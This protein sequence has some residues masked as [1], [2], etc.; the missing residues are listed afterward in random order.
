LVKGCINCGRDSIISNNKYTTNE[1]I[2]KSNE[3]HNNKYDY[4]KVNYINSKNKI[5]IICKEHGEFIQSPDHHLQGQGC[6]ICGEIRTQNFKY[7]NTNQFIEKSK[8]I[9]GNK[10]DYSKT[11]YINSHTNI[12]IICKEHG[13]FYI[14]PN[15]HINSNQGCPKCQKIKQYSKLSIIWLNFISNYYKINIQ[16][17]MNN[18]EFII[19]NTKYKADGYCKETN[20]IYEFHGNYWHGNPK[21]LIV[22]NIIKLQN[23]H[24]V[25]YI[26]IH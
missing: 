12:I 3:K 19:P 9:Y 21:Y 22:M 10:Y 8:N 6:K 2:I 16:H 18:N 23:V 15:N 7:S 4:S 25:N 13:E 17:G 1:F 14:R 26:K 24:L 20:T 5:L 11:E